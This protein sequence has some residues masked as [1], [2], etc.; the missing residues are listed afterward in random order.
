MNPL[1][2]DHNKVMLPQTEMGVLQSPKDKDSVNPS[3]EGSICGGTLVEDASPMSYPLQYWS[4]DDVI[5][6][7]QE[8]IAYQSERLQGIE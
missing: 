5:L 1:H 6:W 7:I 2:P 8:N 4:V 3:L